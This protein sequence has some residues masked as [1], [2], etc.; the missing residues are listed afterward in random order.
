MFYQALDTLI[1][2]VETKL[3]E[4]K[5]TNISIS[6]Y[7]MQL[8]MAKSVNA[9]LPLNTF[10]E[11]IYMPYRDEILDNNIAYFRNLD[12]ASVAADDIKTD[13]LSVS[14]LVKDIPDKDVQFIFH[15][16]SIMVTAIDRYVVISQM[17]A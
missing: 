7:K 12:V 15:Y 4:L 6:T 5:V 10:I 1:D 17:A 11:S 14:M 13:A 3:T 16:L 2:K 8:N 9:M